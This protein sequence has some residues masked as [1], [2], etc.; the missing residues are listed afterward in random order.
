ME[1][2][3]RAKSSWPLGAELPK[4][5]TAFCDAAAAPGKGRPNRPA[6]DG[7]AGLLPV[8]TAAS[9]AVS[10]ALR[11]F[12]KRPA[13][14]SPESVVK[15]GALGARA[16]VGV[17]WQMPSPRIMGGPPSRDAQGRDGISTEIVRSSVL[18]R[19][20]SSFPTSCTNH[21]MPSSL[22]LFTTALLLRP[23]TARSS[24]MGAAQRPFDTRA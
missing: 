4:V 24:C 8:A 21:N 16:G 11:S 3:R 13:S 6:D 2:G 17:G 12:P 15:G 10:A 23:C 7:L 19:C 1:R 20:V 5:G 14:E 18:A 9:G 22:S